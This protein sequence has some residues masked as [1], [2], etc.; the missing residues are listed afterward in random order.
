MDA[1]GNRDISQELSDAVRVML[2]HCRHVLT[3]SN[4]P[5]QIRLS[6]GSA[7]ATFAY[8]SPRHQ[9]ILT[10]LGGLRINAF[11]DFLKS[12]NES[13]RCIAAFQVYML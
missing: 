4:S 13:Y 5:A 12:D 1:A 2:T 8:N 9:T 11:Q 10:Q 6:A 3:A 7:L